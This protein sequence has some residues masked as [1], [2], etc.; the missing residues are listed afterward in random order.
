MPATV[1]MTCEFDQLRPQA[2]DWAQRLRENGVTVIEKCFP[3]TVHGFSLDVEGS[4][5]GQVKAGIDF[6]IDSLKN[7]LV[8]I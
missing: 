7:Y 6:L 5:P 2:E 4:D 8:Q 1:L 3:G